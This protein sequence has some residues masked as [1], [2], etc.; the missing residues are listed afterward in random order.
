[1]AIPIPVSILP[2]LGQAPTAATPPISAINWERIKK[3]RSAL[4]AECMKTCRRYK[5]Q[6]FQM[7]L[8]TEGDDIGICKACIR[9]ANRFKD[10]ALPSVFGKDNEL[11]LGPVPSFLGAS[12]C[13]RIHSSTS[14]A[15]T[16]AAL[17]LY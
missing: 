14:R 4:Q 12:D 13:A 11:D 9:D 15:H 8:A 17:S 2:V 3:L 5:E 1:M 6:W 10:P 7:G 16:R